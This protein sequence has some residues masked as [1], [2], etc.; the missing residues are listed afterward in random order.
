VRTI[1]TPTLTIGFEDSGNPQGFPILLLHGFP[2]DVRAW[3][4]V[5]PML[6]NEG[7]RII[8]PYLRGYGL[9]RIRDARVR[10][11][12]QSALAQDLIELADGLGVIR[13]AVSGYDWGGRTAGI[14]AA[15]H[16]ERVRGTVLIGG[17]LIQDTLAAP[18]P[19]SPERERAFWYQWYFNTERGRL[20][21]EK[22]RRRLCRLLWETWSPTWKFSDEEYNKTAASFDNPDFVDVV[23][24]SYRHRNRNAAGE[25][26]FEET[27]RRLAQRPRIEVPSIVLY[28]SDD[29]VAAPPTAN[30]T[31]DKTNFP[32]LI[33]RRVVPGAGHFMPREKP[34]AVSSALLH[35]LRSTK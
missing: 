35:V 31:A 12:Q 34:A 29:G 27:E 26:R 6:V 15:L 32:A 10:T 20:G 9:T 7:Y 1:D 13:F 14:V 33:D 19:A 21:L 16:P 2:D 18:Q 24:H 8:V 28:G 3:D 17:Y 5:T 22:N 30:S 4:R 25:P 23:I 11:G